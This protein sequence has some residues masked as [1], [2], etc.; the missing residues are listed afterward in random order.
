MESRDW[1]SEVFS[2]DLKKI[3]QI[4]W[5]WKFFSYSFFFF[6]DK[7]SVVILWYQNFI[8]FYFCTYRFS[9]VCIKSH[10]FNLRVK[11][12]VT[13]T[14]IIWSKFLFL[15]K[16]FI[17]LLIYSGLCIVF[18]ICVL[19]TSNEMRTPISRFCV[20]CNCRLTKYFFLG[21]IRHWL[22]FI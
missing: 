20:I 21:I 18:P 15:Y 10:W 13:G 12:I 17:L 6:Y 4:L 16:Y 7:N 11:F 19:S 1:I 9:S 3:V 2:S 8:L 22:F 14:C 5:W